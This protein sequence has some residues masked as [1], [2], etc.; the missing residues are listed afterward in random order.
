MSQT[1]T[2]PVPDSLQEHLAYLKLRFV[3]DNCE[4]LSKLADKE[5]W[6]HLR[7]L[8]KVV[9]F[10]SLFRGRDDIYPRR[11]ESRKTGKAETTFV[12]SGAARSRPL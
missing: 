3:Q 10:R 12:P 2:L 4:A 7:F 8:A 6:P 9:F 11:F 5:Q 1:P